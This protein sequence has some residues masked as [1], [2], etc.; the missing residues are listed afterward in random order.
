MMIGQFWGTSAAEGIPSPYCRCEN[1]REAREKKGKYQRKRSS[2]RVS[3]SIIIDL[4]ADAVSQS[5][6]YGD[7]TDI[8]H[9]LIT[10]THDDHL[11][12]HMLMEAF[13][14]SEYR[15]GPIHYY[16]TDEAYN[17]VDKWRSNDW[18]LKGMVPKWEEENIV[19]FHKLTYGQ[20]IEID[21]I[22][23][24]PFKGNHKGN[25]KETSAMYL[26]ELP[27][28]RTL[29]YGLDSGPYFKE[30]IDALKNVYVNIYISE[31]TGGTK[32]SAPE[33]THMNLQNVYDLAC[34]L[35]EQG[36][37]DKNSILYLTHIN[38]RTGHD[39]MLEGVEKLKF[40]VKTVVA[41]DGLKIF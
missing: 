12:Q 31:A 15:Q 34:T 23:V 30:T 33:S 13:W 1:C 26:L 8:N 37:I 11:N 4:G 40:P 7:L 10:H 22:G 24:T 14:G 9:V 5:M 41:F 19:Q 38:H 32:P 16:L 20:R 6:E 3:D 21:G 27:D 39:Q 35:Y 28:G 2:F 17:I 25:M 18:I 36:T 29:F